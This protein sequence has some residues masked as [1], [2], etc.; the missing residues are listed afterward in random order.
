[1]EKAGR[2]NTTRPLLLLHSHTQ[3]TI[4]PKKQQK[5]I[6][7]WDVLDA[8]ASKINNMPALSRYTLRPGQKPASAPGKTLPTQ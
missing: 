3:P 8:A 6:L 4:T 5:G 1:M 2:H 7:R